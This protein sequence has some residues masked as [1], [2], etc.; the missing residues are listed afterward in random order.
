MIDLKLKIYA[1]ILFSLVTAC[2]NNENSTFSNTPYT[3][4]QDTKTLIDNNCV[5]CHSPNNLAV[6]GTAGD[7]SLEAYSDSFAKRSAMIFAIET[8]TMPEGFTLSVADKELLLNWLNGGAPEGNPNDF[9]RQLTYFDDALPI[10]FENC[11]S[12]HG[13]G[14]SVPSLIDFPAVGSYLS[15]TPNLNAFNDLLVNF[16]QDVNHNGLAVSQESLDGLNAWVNDGMVEGLKPSYEPKIK[17]IIA[18][19]CAAA[20]HNPS[21]SQGADDLTDYVVLFEKLFI[22][23]VGELEAETV[24]YQVANDHMI[25]QGADL[26]L[27]EE[28]TLEYWIDHSPPMPVSDPGPTPDDIA[29]NNGIKEII[30]FY[31]VGCHVPRNYHAKT[32]SRPLSTYAAIININGL[33]KIDSIDLMH[34]RVSNET[35]PKQNANYLF[36]NDPNNQ[37]FYDK[38]TLL[39]WL[40]LGAPENP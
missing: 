8:A 33:N 3:Y 31:C 5:I 38:R 24:S 36:S 15:I 13:I 4:Y 40:L 23:Q 9:S 22:D 30:D 2:D 21:A 16:T 26:S 11:I 39:D 28:A 29:Y 35:M 12:C 7:F 27:L 18:D 20:C 34:E 14:M 1:I 10:F 32:G 17:T 19:N 25:D 37:S 6:T